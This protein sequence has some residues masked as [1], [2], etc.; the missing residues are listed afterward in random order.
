[1]VRIQKMLFSMFMVEDMY[2]VLVMTTEG[3]SQKAALVGQPGYV[4]SYAN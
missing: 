2:L 3:L 1:M 4:T